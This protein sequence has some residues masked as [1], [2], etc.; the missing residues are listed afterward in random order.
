MKTLGMTNA[1]IDQLYSG[2]QY[3]VFA[4]NNT[5]GVHFIPESV[6]EAEVHNMTK[7]DGCA[8]LIQQCRELGN[9]G[10][11]EWIGTNDTVNEAC[12]LATDW[13]TA[14]VTGGLPGL[15][16]RTLFDV[17]VVRTD[18]NDPCPFYLPAQNYLNLPTVQAALGVPLNFT[19]DSNVVTN[20]F[21]S[22]SAPSLKIG[23][24]DS[25]RK[26]IHDLEYAI[27][28]GAN[29][30]LIYGDRDYICNWLGGEA[31]AKNLAW[32]HQQGF[33]GAG[34]E[35]TVT[36]AKYDGGVTKQVSSPVLYHGLCAKIDSVREIELHACVRCRT[37]GQCISARN[38]LSNF[39][40]QY[41]WHR[42]GDG[43]EASGRSVRHRRAKR[44]SQVE[45]C[46]AEVSG[47]LYGRREVSKGECMDE[48]AVW[49]W[50][51]KTRCVL[52]IA[53]LALSGLSPAKQQE[54]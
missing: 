33:L 27:A 40:A 50:V 5:Y 31:I 28:A 11:P 36:N 10:D 52:R 25:I 30:A 23:T 19:Y 53:V 34:Y 43:E 24:G 45:E 37:C 9:I 2:P 7:P 54:N 13:C 18:G 49:L 46:V 15:T 35:K 4:Y 51:I 44:Q 21:G 22:Y 47:V 29:V 1:C 8:D 12:N 42:C 6:A 16:N 48:C 39:H 41:V 17:A 14:Y 3:P 38:S 20:V 32:S 26:G